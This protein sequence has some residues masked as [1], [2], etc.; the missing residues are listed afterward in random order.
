VGILVPAFLARGHEVLLEAIAAR[1]GP[2]VAYANANIGGSA[3][4]TIAAHAR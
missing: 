1:P 4:T 3:T 2:G